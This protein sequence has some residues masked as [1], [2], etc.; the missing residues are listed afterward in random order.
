MPHLA[1]RDRYDLRVGTARAGVTVSVLR[2]AASSCL[3]PSRQRWGARWRGTGR[4]HQND[5]APGLQRAAFRRAYLELEHRIRAFASL[6]IATLDRVA[7]VQHL[8]E[9]HRKAPEPDEA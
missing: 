7:L 3:G 9:I 5:G 6:P 1:T 4:G 8:D 2:P